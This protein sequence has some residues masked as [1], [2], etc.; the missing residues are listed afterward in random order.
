MQRLVTADEM[1][2]MD[3]EAIENRGI[4]GFDLMTSAGEGV[5]AAVLESFGDIED[6]RVAHYQVGFKMGFSLD[7]QAHGG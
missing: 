1:R 3:R 7:E 2:A 4:P 6:A 5:A